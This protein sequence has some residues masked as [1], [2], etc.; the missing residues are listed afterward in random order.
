MSPKICVEKKAADYIS[1]HGGVIT[2]RC[3]LVGK[4]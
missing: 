1:K 4:G 3:A 2:I